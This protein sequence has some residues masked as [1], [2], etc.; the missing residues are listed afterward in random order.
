MP[1][2]ECVTTNDKGKPV[3]GDETEKREGGRA[4][5]YVMEKADG[6]TT[7]LVMAMPSG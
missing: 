6:A 3:F 4:D 2:A 1:D 5:W 7:R